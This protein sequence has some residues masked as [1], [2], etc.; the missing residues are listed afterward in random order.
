MPIN[1]NGGDDPSTTIENLR[2]LA[3]DLERMMMFV[4][5]E[6][7]LEDAPVLE[8]WSFSYLSHPTLDG[9]VTGHPLLGSREIVT[10]E[11][12]ALDTDFRWVR[13]ANR[14]F[15]LGKQA[16]IKESN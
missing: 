4:P 1:F 3:D 2:A 14:F 6:A 8:D 16:G 10:S 7:E 12:Y 15:R 5:G 13:T 11:V 9:T